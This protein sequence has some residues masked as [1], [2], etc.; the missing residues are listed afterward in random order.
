MNFFDYMVKNHQG[1]N[2]PAGD[3]TEDMLRSGDSFPK[4]S[5]EKKVIQEYLIR[6]NACPQCMEVFRKV[7]KEY[8]NKR[9]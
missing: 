2:S 9:G 4:D 5:T 8:L 6:N 3:L 1:E 7:W